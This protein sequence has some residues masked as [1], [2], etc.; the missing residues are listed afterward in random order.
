MEE[1]IRKMCK[2]KKLSSRDD[3]FLQEQLDSIIKKYCDECEEL[4]PRNTYRL[5]NRRR[6]KRKKGF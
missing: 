2:K 3:S 4:E 6:T 1:A 5:V